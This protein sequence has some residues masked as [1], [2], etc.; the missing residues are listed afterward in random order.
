[1]AEILDP[2]ELQKLDQEED[3]AAMEVRAMRGWGCD[4]G[5]GKVTL[6]YSLRGDGGE[7]KVTLDTKKY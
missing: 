2:E 1:V 7:G 5:D 3:G 6:N 4:G